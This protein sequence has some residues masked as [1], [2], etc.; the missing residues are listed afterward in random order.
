MLSIYN[1]SPTNETPDRHTKG[2]PSRSSARVLPSM[3]RGIF[4]TLRK[5][6]GDRPTCGHVQLSGERG[7]PFTRQREGRIAHGTDVSVLVLDL[8]EAKIVRHGVCAYG[9]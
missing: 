1:P 6:D 5:S 3:D 2:R 4:Q 7:G 9:A 8:G